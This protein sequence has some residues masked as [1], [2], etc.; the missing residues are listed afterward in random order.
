MQFRR[1]VSPLLTFALL[2]GAVW[3][4]RQSPWIRESQGWSPRPTGDVSEIPAPVPTQNSKLSLLGYKGVVPT[5][6][7]NSPAITE[8]ASKTP[9]VSENS[10]LKLANPQIA[11]RVQ[12]PTQRREQIAKK[13]S[14][15]NTRT[16][17]VMRHAI[18]EW[19]QQGGVSC[20]PIPD[21]QNTSSPPRREIEQLTRKT[22]QEIAQMLAEDELARWKALSIAPV[23]DSTSQINSL[24][25]GPVE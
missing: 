21:F 15:L 3:I 13:V 4:F 24:P 6:D 1:P 20:R 19:K 22:E 7:D 25:P 5:T 8:S 12:L 17:Q 11:E 18:Q 23:K 16:E 9:L 10:S 14:D 2:L